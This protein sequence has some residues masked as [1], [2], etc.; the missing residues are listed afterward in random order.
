[1]HDFESPELFY[2]RIETID[3]KRK[4]TRLYM[5]KFPLAQYTP[6]RSKSAIEKNSFVPMPLLSRAVSSYGG[7]RKKIRLG[8]KKRTRKHKN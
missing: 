5:A 3:T 2:N 8:K 1:M 4:V 6:F 7:S